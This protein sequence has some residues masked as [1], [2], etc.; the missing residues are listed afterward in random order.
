MAH[1]VT[2]AGLD[3]ILDMV[4]KQTGVPPASLYLGLFSSQTP[5]TVPARTA[6]GGAVPTGWTEVTGSGYARIAITS[7]NWGV[8]STSGSGR[9]ITAAQKTFA[10]TG[11]WTTANGFFIATAL[12]S[13]VG[14]IIIGFANFDS[15]LARL[16]SV[17]G[18]QL[19]LTASI[20]LNG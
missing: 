3:Y 1:I 7:G 19:K 2:D 18:D 13:G 20:L 12:T 11:V 14:D 15:G 4:F 8:E 9:Q 5:V 10:A 6:T 16:L 17:S